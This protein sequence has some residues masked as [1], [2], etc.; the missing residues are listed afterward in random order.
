[1]KL[2]MERQK[3]ADEWEE[4]ARKHES[5]AEGDGRKQ[6]TLLIVMKQPESSQT[7]RL[8]WNTSIQSRNC[9]QSSGGLRRYGQLGY[10][11]TA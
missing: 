9:V 7:I 10:Y 6:Q 1:M 11:V 4:K 2:E 8:S 5:E 3:I